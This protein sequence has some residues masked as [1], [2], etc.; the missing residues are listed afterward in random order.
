MTLYEVIL[1]PVNKVDLNIPE[2]LQKVNTLHNLFLVSA[3]RSCFLIG[4]TL[5]GATLQQGGTLQC[6]AASVYCKQLCQ[7]ETW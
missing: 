5:Q 1:T 4:T 6:S 3:T 7:H 2:T